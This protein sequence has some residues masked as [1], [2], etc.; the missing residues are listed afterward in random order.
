MKDDLFNKKSIEKIS[1]PDKLDEY[2]KVTN[3]GIW[4]LL[5]A[6]VVFLAATVI[7][8]TSAQMVTNISTVAEVVDGKGSV[9]IAEEDIEDFSD[10]ANVVLTQ[11]NIA[12]PVISL[13]TSAYEA[14]DVMDE[15]MLRQA[16]IAKNEWVYI[17]TFNAE[18][19]ENGIYISEVQYNGTNLFTYVFN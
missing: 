18:D 17:A 1:S 13:S 4:L 9:Y 14:S 5:I 10:D 3:P 12:K 19:V 8:S 11:L 2:I 6:I 16:K 7:W 15:F